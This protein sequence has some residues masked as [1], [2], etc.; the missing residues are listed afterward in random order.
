[1]KLL[2]SLAIAY[3]GIPILF[4][5]SSSPAVDQVGEMFLLIPLL[6]LI[7][8]F[9]VFYFIVIPLVDNNKSIQG[10]FVLAILFSLG[11]TFLAYF[12][13]SYLGSPEPVVISGAVVSKNRGRGKSK[14]SLTIQK[15]EKVKLYITR[16]VWDDIEI[17]NHCSFNVNKGVLG[18]YSKMNLEKNDVLC[19]MSRE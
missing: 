9:M 1:M 12:V 19:K 11:T 10:A 13:D 3:I 8:F 6:S 17:G 16:E 18:Y 15:N 2:N 4:Y 14:P 5:L 7:P